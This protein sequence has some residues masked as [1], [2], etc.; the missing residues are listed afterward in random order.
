MRFRID[1]LNRLTQHNWCI[2]VPKT[3]WQGYK[4][5]SQYRNLMMLVIIIKSV[6]IGQTLLS[7]VTAFILMCYPA[8]LNHGSPNLSRFKRTSPTNSQRGR[9]IN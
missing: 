2:R 4:H 9:H 7:F 8:T 5:L 6:G 1:F 3:T